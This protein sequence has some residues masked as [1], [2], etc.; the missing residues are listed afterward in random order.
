M[1]LKNIELF[2]LYAGKIL[3]ELYVSFP[4]KIDIDVCDMLEMKISEHDMSVPKECMI[5]NDTLEWLKESGFVYYEEC[6]TYAFRR[7]VLSAKGLEVLKATP[8]SIK[9]KDGIGEQL[10]DVVATGKK[11]AIR[12]TVDTILASASHLF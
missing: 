1:A 8:A 5:F 9:R 4:L 6:Y 12:R 2:D 10:R 11:E 3:A 7:V